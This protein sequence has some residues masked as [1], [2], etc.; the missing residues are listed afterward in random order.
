MVFAPFRS[1]TG[2]DFAHFC[3]QSR[4]VFEDYKS[5]CMDVLIVSIPNESERRSDMLIQNGF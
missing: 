5:V 4:M 3:L 1:E 2:V